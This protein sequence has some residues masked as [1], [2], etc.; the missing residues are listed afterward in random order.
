MQHQVTTQIEVTAPAERVWIVL[1][2]W[3]AYPDWNPF[4]RQIAGTQAQ[5]ERLRVLLQLAHGRGVRIH[6]KVR[7]L[8]PPTELAWAGS[9]WLPGMLGVEQ[10]FLLEPLAGDST[11]L[12][13]RVAFSGLLIPMM[14]RSLK[15]TTRRGA[16]LMN[17]ALKG[18]VENYGKEK[19]GNT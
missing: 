18:K 9:L 11:L 7:T 17:A 5:S 3:D 6:A 16:M 4:I 15:R 13:Q 1:T 19:P 2:E 14:W 10:Q 8:S 12:I